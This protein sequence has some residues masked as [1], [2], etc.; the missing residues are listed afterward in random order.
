MALFVFLFEREEDPTL[1]YFLAQYLKRKKQFIR[2][3]EIKEEGKIFFEDGQTGEI[4]S[5]SESIPRSNEISALKRRW[6]EYLASFE[7][8][9]DDK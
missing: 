9:A 1:L 3:P 7:Q 6:T 5:V 4:Y 2:R 8:M